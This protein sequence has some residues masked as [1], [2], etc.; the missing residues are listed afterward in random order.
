MNIDNPIIKSLLSSF[1][2]PDDINKC[3]TF[4]EQA[5]LACQKVANNSE[6]NTETLHIV[7]HNIAVLNTELLKL[8]NLIESQEKTIDLLLQQQNNIADYLNKKEK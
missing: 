8:S 6:T 5:K 2:K 4:F 3:I 1:I 7:D